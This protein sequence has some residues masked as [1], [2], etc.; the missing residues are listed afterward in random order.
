MSD[1]PQDPLA[2][3]AVHTA[4]TRPWAGSECVRHFAAAGVRGV[5]FWRFNFERERPTDLGRRAREAGLAVVSLARGGFF[6]AA[7]AVGRRAAID[8]N[9]RAIDEAQALGAPSLVL[10]CGAVPGMPLEVARAQIRDGIAACLDHAAAAGVVLAIE[11]LHP[12]Y[13]A[14]RSA[15]NTFAQANALCAA[16]GHHRNLG[17][18]LDVYH[19]WWD[20]DLGAGIAAAAQA[21][22]LTAF[23]ICDWMSPTTDLLNDRGVMGEGCIDVAGISSAVDAAKFAGFREVEVFSDRHWA[24]DQHDVL[25]DV[26]AAYRRTYP[27][28]HTTP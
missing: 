5:T 10:V 21:G 3:L 23:H 20:P 11:P 12:M 19:T 25:G 4:T 7:S 14:E 28:D 8:D 22:H 27:F 17:V 18:A 15:V 16:L 24:R 1:T 9:L 2:R 6:P 13:A 26:V